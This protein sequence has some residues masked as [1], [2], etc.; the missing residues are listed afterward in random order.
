LSR[1][2]DIW[3][4]TALI[5]MAVTAAG[6]TLGN[7]ALLFSARRRTQARPPGWLRTAEAPRR[8]ERL[9]YRHHRLFGL[10]VLAGAS[11]FLVRTAAAGLVWPDA[12]EPLWHAVYPVL[13]VLNLA[14]LPFG[15]VMLIRPSLLKRLEQAAN[16]WID[17]QHEKTL[18]L[19]RALIGLYCLAALL[20]L[21]LERLQ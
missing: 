10:A 2:H 15:A 5:V 21:I 9:V 6:W 4:L 20:A 1:A 16:R 7:L 11:L 3:L 17:W 8:I 12:S 13:A 14:L 19:A 18:A